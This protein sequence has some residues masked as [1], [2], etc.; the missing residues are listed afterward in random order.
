MAKRHFMSISEFCELYGA[1]KNTIHSLN[2]QGLI[3][4]SA[5]KTTNYI[6]YIDANHFIRRR[7]FIEKIQLQAHDYYYLL[8]PY[9]SDRQIAKAVAKTFNCKVSAGSM[10][11][12]LK[13]DL[14]YIT[15]KSIT[16]TKASTRL[17]CF[18]RWARWCI[19]QIKSLSK[20]KHLKLNKVVKD[21]LD[22][23]MV[24]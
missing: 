13:T 14:F 3:P 20:I 15:D 1:K 8:Q 12:F 6:T 21:I 10:I 2:S 18:Y 23:R 4:K 7:E 22:K 24:A 11:T 5:I 16:S 19:M 9:F 17:W